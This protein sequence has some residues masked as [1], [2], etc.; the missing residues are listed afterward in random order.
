MQD[1]PLY[2]EIT[3]DMKPGDPSITVKDAT[4]RWKRS[5]SH[6]RRVLDWMTHL[7][8]PPTMTEVPGSQPKAWERI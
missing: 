5:D 4:A 2:V 6:T 3:R 7:E 8:K 1:D